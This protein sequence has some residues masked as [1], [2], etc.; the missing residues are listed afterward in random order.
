[1]P[2][3]RNTRLLYRSITALGVVLAFFLTLIIPQHMREG[4]DWS[5]QFATQNFSQGHLTADGATIGLEQSEASLYGGTLSQYVTVGDNRWALTE[6]PG[7]IF[8]LLPFYYMHAPA[9]G[10]LAL[11][12]GMA[13]VAYIL[14]KRLRDEKTACLGTLLLLFTPVALAMMQ[15]TYADSFAATAFLS[16][17]GGLYIYYVLAARELSSRIGSVILFLAGLL[18][19]WSV[20][21]NYN[22][23]VVVLVFVIH[24]IFMFIRSRSRGPRVPAF[25]F[26]I[27]GLAVPFSLL[28]FYQKLVFG[29]PWVFGFQY[30][31]LPIGFA[32]RYLRLN[33]EYV[34]AALLVGFPLLLGAA[35]AYC[36]SLYYKI[37]AFFDGAGKEARNDPLPELSWETMLLLGGWIL[38]VFGLYLNFEFTANSRVGGMSFII[39]A[40]YYLPAVLPL[41]ICAVL[42]LTRVPRK[43]AVSVTLLAFAWGVIFFSQSALS[44]P[45]VP[46]HSPY[47]P[48]AF[49]IEENRAPV[50]SGFADLSHTPG[51]WDRLI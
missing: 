25:M 24:F 51:A 44:F 42:L 34:T 35:L 20:A 14:L 7:Y 31:Q 1:M 45:V 28:L 46:P 33:I 21:A 36:G 9:L 29:S 37:T 50:I 3:D 22:N 38:A 16:M 13:F 2:N 5:F 10:D 32:L 48:F 49:S 8:Y 18:L 17:G 47:N 30:S 6:A 27:L 15:R 4:T 12:A 43:L 26:M 41:T 39:M 40:R 19:A 23:S 11:A